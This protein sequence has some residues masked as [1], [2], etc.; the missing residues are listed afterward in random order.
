M[1][2]TTIIEENKRFIFWFSKY[3]PQDDLMF[4]ALKILLILTI[5]TEFIF[6][7][8]K[9]HCFERILVIIH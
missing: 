9:I 8:L 3:F 5:N 1:H 6:R 4:N 7:I 2:K